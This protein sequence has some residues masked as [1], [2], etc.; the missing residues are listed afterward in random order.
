MEIH[1]IDFNENYVIISDVHGNYVALEAIIEDAITKYGQTI[2]G[3]ILLGDY[4]CD[5]PHGDKVVNILQ[6]LKQKY[7]L[8][9]IKG[10][11]SISFP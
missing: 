8:Y 1:D 5:F 9:A 3:F 10:K 11:R 7:K 4:S 6:S 2:A